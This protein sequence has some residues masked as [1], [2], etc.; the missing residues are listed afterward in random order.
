MAA[1]VAQGHVGLDNTALL[2][3]VKEL[4]GACLVRRWKDPG[5]SS[6]ADAHSLQAGADNRRSI[7]RARV[8][9]MRVPALLFGPDTSMA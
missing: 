9:R 1:L 4:S 8:A 5:G 6:S 7:S 3:L 2:R